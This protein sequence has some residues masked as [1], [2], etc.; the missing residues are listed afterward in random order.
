MNILASEALTCCMSW[1]LELILVA[2]D[3]GDCE[4][5]PDGRD[6]QDQLVYKREKKPAS[7]CVVT[8]PTAISRI[9]EGYI[10]GRRPL[11]FACLAENC[12]LGP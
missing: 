4:I 6:Y 12:G 2:V 5:V 3:T 1:M 10:A 9:G 7:Q 8:L 11:D